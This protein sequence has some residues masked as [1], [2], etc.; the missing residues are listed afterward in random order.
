[1]AAVASVLDVAIT[2]RDL[3]DVVAEQPARIPDSLGETLSPGKSIG[4]GAK[5][6]R[7]AASHTDILVQRITGRQAYVGVMAEKTGERV[8][9]VGGGTVL[10]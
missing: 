7:V 1:M 9:D 3:G 4:V 2:L 5:D 6:E 10:L 8:T